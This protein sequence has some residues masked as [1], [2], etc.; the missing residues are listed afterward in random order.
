MA[1]TNTFADRFIKAKEIVD[2]HA[3]TCTRFD[4]FEFHVYNDKALLRMVNRFY[5]NKLVQQHAA[6]L[7]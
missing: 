6:S 5:I 4:E 3:R 7:I 1:K 2:E